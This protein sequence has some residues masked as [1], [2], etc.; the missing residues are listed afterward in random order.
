MDRTILAHTFSQFQ[1]N[2]SHGLIRPLAEVVGNK[3][4]ELN[5][6][7]FC[8]SMLVFITTHYDILERKYPYPTIFEI[9]VSESTEFSDG[10]KSKYIAREVD[11]KKIVP[12]AYFEM[13]MAELPDANSRLLINLSNTPGTPYIFVRSSDA[14]Y[15][16]LAWEKKGDDQIF[17]K[18]ISTPLPK[19]FDMNSQIYKMS[20]NSASKHYV[21]SH[22]GDRDRYLISGLSLIDDNGSLYDYASD[23]EIVNFCAKQTTQVTGLKNVP[24]KLKELSAAL[25]TSQI[26]LVQERL[27]K[28]NTIS[29]F[30]LGYQEEM[31][32]GLSEYLKSENGIKTIV[33]YLEKYEPIEYKNFKDKHQDT[34]DIE[35]SEKKEKIEEAEGRIKELNESKANLSDEVQKLIKQREIEVQKPIKSDVKKFDEQ[36][37]ASAEIAAYLHNGNKNLLEDNKKLEQ[38]I[39]SKKHLVD[40]LV[41][42]EE[43]NGRVLFLEQLKKR[44]E[45]AHKVLEETTKQLQIE[46]Q[47]GDDALRKRLTE[48]KPF[49]EAVNGSFISEEEERRKIH[50]DVNSSSNDVGQREVIKAIQKIFVSNGRELDDWQ[51][52]NLLI[53][54]QQSFITF[55]AGLPGVGKTSLARL[56][57]EIQQLK[58]RMQEVSVARGW[59]SQKELIGFFNPLSSRFQASHTGLYGFLKA[60]GAEDNS[61]TAAMAYALLDEANL[62][63]IEHYWSVFMAMTDGEGEKELILGREQLRIP[64]NLRFIAT[65][66]YDGTTEPLSE[67]VVDRAPIIVLESKDLPRPISV[68]KLDFILP[69]SAVKMNELFGNDENLPDFG[70][71]EQSAYDRIKVILTGTGSVPGRPISISPRK[72]KAIRQFCG[73]AR[74]IMNEDSDYFAFDIA[75]LQH[76]LPLIRGNGVH[77]GQRLEK[78]KE[79]LEDSSLHYSAKYL[80]QIISYGKDDLHTYDFFCW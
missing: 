4:I 12:K 30:C 72:E 52:L 11:A 54:T 29:D 64:D 50:V 46:L 41:N 33:K 62:S 56:L 66:N 79:E 61:Q 38:E 73:K 5:E 21:I 76:I 40:G 49:I 37:V 10:R 57:A 25:Q 7:N 39:A 3:L 51:V 75:V 19:F 47:A 69:I 59:T 53:C 9:T 20:T 48:L 1:N 55:L 2:P 34:L 70:Y 23:N 14:L 58:P 35:L 8:P 80:N 65:I 74:G 77:F 26:P 60:L 44:E 67:R 18:I 24:E 42:I 63:P 31:A 6:D 15:G 22:H 68:D 16:P 28:L 36:E 71:A 45:S 17:L 78:L 13:I 27:I 43:I 32:K